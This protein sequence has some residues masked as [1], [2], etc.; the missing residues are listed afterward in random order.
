VRRSSAPLSATRASALLGLVLTSAAIY[1]VSASTAFSLREIEVPPLRY[2]DPTAIRS[3]LA[4]R[5]GVNL[6]GL[7]TESLVDPLLDMS[8]VAAAGIQIAL[9]DRI[10]VQVEE[11]EPI[12]I[13]EVGEQRFLVDRR[14]VLFA[15]VA[16]M[17]PD[18]AAA[19]PVVADRRI[20]SE[21]ALVETDTLDPVVLDAATRLASLVPA[22]VGSAASSLA[23]ELGDESGFVV[24]AAPQGWQAIFGFYTPSLRTTDLIPGQV[25]LLRSLL[26]DREATVARIVLADDTNGTYQPK[27]TPRPSPTGRR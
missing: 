5:E 7:R 14:G 3:S 2:T 27:T 16:A 21:A 15:T 17:P 13:W 23:V 6:F 8:G 10:V 12:L 20:A 25:R 24:R 9:P 4:I 19:L 22:D 18:A 1:G 26:A 11:R